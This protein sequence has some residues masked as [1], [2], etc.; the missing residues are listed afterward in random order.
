MVFRNI[1]NSLAMRWR[2]SIPA[3][4]FVEHLALLF[5]AGAAVQSLRLPLAAVDIEFRRLGK[6]LLL[7]EGQ[8]DRLVV[9][10]AAVIAVRFLAGQQAVVAGRQRR[11]IA[12]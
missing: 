2:T 7:A 1:W 3:H 5:G 6:A 4:D 9:A 12:L 8:R 10:L 11:L